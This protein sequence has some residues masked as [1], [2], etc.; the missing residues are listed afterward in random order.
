[1]IGVASASINTS[2]VDKINATLVADPT[3]PRE[4]SLTQYDNHLNSMPFHGAA[5]LSLTPWYGKLAAFS[6]AYVAF[7]FYFQAGL[8]FASL[9]SNCPVTVCSDTHPGTTITQVEQHR[10]RREP[11]QRSAAQQRWSPRPLP[12]RRHPR[13]PE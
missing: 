12:R 13:V 3:N 9:T 11:E 6:Q 7:D 8:A 2:L 4:P 10:P 5:Y 1:M